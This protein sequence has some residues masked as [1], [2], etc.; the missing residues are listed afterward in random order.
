[1]SAISSV[2][3]PSTNKWAVDAYTSTAHLFARADVDKTT[4]EA[5]RATCYERGVPVT[6][7]VGVLVEIAR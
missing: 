3:P 6:R 5:F 2:S 1:M 4:W 7:G